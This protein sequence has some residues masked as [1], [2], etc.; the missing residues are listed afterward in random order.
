MVVRSRRYYGFPN[1]KSVK[2]HV[3]RETPN[4]FGDLRKIKKLKK[5]NNIISRRGSDYLA[6]F[7]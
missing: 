3:R 1:M 2:S 4:L 7:K 6:Y 5:R